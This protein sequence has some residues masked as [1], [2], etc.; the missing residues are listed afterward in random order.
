[1]SI[2]SNN[3]KGYSGPEHWLVFCLKCLIMN[4]IPY[5]ITL[6]RLQADFVLA[7]SSTTYFTSTHFEIVQTRQSFRS[8]IIIVFLAVATDQNTTIEFPVYSLVMHVAADISNISHNHSYITMTHYIVGM[9]NYQYSM[10]ASIV[11]Y[12]LEVA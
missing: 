8:T 12:G 11:Y 6:Y 5:E 4:T 1:M 10:H 3:D 9:Q 7:D 2:Y